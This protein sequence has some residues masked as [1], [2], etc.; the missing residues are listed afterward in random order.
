V[1]PVKNPWEN[2]SLQVYELHMQLETVQQLQTLNAI[3]KEQLSQ[4]PICSLAVLGVAGGNG[5]EYVDPERIV[6]VVGVDIN[7]EYLQACKSRFPDLCDILTLK[8]ADLSYPDCGPI[9]AVDLVI[10]NLFIEYIGVDCF[11]RQVKR[12]L[13]R[14]VSCVIQKNPSVEFVSV[15]PY[16]DSFCEISQLHRDIE[17][18]ELI[19]AMADIGYALLLLREYRLPNQKKFIRLDFQSERRLTG[20]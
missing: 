18:D 4:Y 2:V 14:Y 7:A 1:L 5:L 13:P 10:A 20:K 19:T 11:A 12:C 8:K 3:M 17:H 9:P 6:K 16:A 15:S